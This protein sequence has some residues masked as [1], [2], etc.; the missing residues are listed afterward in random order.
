MN[1]TRDFR[2]QI[3][4][5]AAFVLSL[6]ILA[7]GVALTLR[8]DLGSSPISC[9]PYVLSRA[10][11]GGLTIGGYIFCMQFFFVAAQV[12]LLRK[13]FQKIQLLQLG[14]CL[15]F[16]SFTDLAMFLTEPFQWSNTLSGYT[17]RWLQLVL[18]GAILG[19]GV[20]WEVRCDVLMIPGEGLPATI[21]KVFRIDFGKVKI[22]FDV[23][24][25]LAAVVLCYVFWG[26]WR[27]DM[28]GIGTLFSMFYVGIIVRL[29]NPHLSWLD[30]WL[31]GGQTPPAATV[32]A[33][34]A[35]LVITV[36]R[37]YGSGGHELAERLAG[38]LKIPFYDK[39]IL[40]AAARELGSSPERLL[41]REQSVSNAGMLNM[42]VE[43]GGGVSPEMSLSEDDALFMAESRVIRALASRKSCV[44]V[45]RCADFVLK[46]HPRCFRIFVRSDLDFA[47]G[48]V[49]GYT[50]LPQPEVDRAILQVNRERAN[51]Y[52]RYTG[53]KWDDACNYD[54]VLNT[55]RIPIDRAV[56]L[57][58]TEKR[59]LKLP[60][61]AEHRLRLVRGNASYPPGRAEAASF[62]PVVSFR[63]RRK[64]SSL[65]LQSANG[66]VW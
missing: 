49:A 3:R 53:R 14:V 18:G 21:A 55:S 4:R 13:D 38:A 34:G 62:S 5:Y 59:H 66:P 31:T 47:R 40:F 63:I 35:P 28:V 19:I 7:L 32:S 12:A 44:I 29:V 57:I 56:A 9:P 60:L 39:S 11:Q 26:R 30:N 8:A 10:P 45:G 48:R 65:P 27:W 51:H 61:T 33:D 23:I 6:F 17:L 42:I 25:V 15:L 37:Q 41:P 20:A 64:Y 24:L 16:G 52:R 22:V 54:L 36:S 50:S 58:L 1:T 43:N 2:E 46:D